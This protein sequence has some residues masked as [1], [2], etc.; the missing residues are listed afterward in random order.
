ME[1]EDLTSHDHSH[2]FTIF[3]LPRS[4]ET[5]VPVQLLFV[6]FDRIAARFKAKAR[7]IVVS[8]LR[9]TVHVSDRFK[10]RTSVANL[11]RIESL[12]PSRIRAVEKTTQEQHS[13]RSASR[14]TVIQCCR[15]GPRHSKY[16]LKLESNLLVGLSTLPPSVP[17]QRA[18]QLRIW[19]VLTA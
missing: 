3:C 1:I 12:L 18:F 16:F 17:P 2:A 5:F 13:A 6:L 15:R 11:H 19:K 4:H 9:C 14:S 7:L 10:C 8:T